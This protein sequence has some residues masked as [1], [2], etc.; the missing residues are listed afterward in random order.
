MNENAS[1]S[2]MV[3]IEGANL[4]L[5]N[6][7]QLFCGVACFVDLVVV[8]VAAALCWKWGLMTTLL[9]K[10]LCWLCCVLM[11]NTHSRK[12]ECGILW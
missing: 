3:S 11:L 6:H 4:S 8:V 10:A 7:C 9:F 5:V 1:L 12:L 2:V